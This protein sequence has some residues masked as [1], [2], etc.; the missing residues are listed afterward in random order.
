MTQQQ[1]SPAASK[2]AYRVTNWPS[3][4]LAL[5]ARGEVTLWLHEEVLHG[6]RAVGAKGMR[7]SDAAI[8]CALSVRAVY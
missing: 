2:Q 7:T 8:L 3:C 5:A 6:W 1:P 4:N